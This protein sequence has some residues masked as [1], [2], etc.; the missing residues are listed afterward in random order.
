MNKRSRRF[1]I[2]TALSVGFFLLLCIVTFVHLG[3]VEEGDRKEYVAL[4]E[5]TDPSYAETKAPYIAKQQH[6]RA[7]KE[8][9]YTDRNQRLQLRLYSADTELI[10]DH[11]DK[12]TDIIEKMQDVICYM[13]EELYYELP[14]GQQVTQLPSGVFILKNDPSHIIEKNDQLKPM[15]LIRYLDA[16]EATYFYHADR[17]IAEQVNIGRFAVPGHILPHS[18][19]TYKARMSG[20][21]ESVELSFKGNNLNFK[22]RHFKAA[23]HEAP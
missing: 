14:D 13:Q 18:L 5:R 21:A 11:H 20:T 19:D 15:Q 6:R 1:F 17:F 10:L 23:I 12:Q 2:T 3:L 8:L 16:A 9:W 22:A 4:R 7:H